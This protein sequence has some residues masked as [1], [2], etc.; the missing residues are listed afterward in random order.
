MRH[1]YT[2]QLLYLCVILLTG[3]Q[4]VSCG[5]KP[6]GTSSCT[7]DSSTYLDSCAN[8][9][10]ISPDADV[11]EAS[12]SSDEGHANPFYLLGQAFVKTKSQLLIIFELLLNVLLLLSLILYLA[13]HF[14]Q[15]KVYKHFPTSLL[16]TF[17]KSIQDPGE[18]APPKPVTLLGRVVA[19]IIGLVGVA[20]FALPAGII[21]SG[22]IAA[23][24][25]EKYAV[26]I[27]E[28]TETLQLAFERKK[29]RLTG[30]QIVPKY[31][32]VVELQ[33]RLG[34]KED[35]ILDAVRHDPHFRL[36]NLSITQN[37][38][39]H[40]QDKL[41]VE[42]YTLNTVY[43]QCIDKGSKV[44][45]FSP[46]NIVDPIMGWW[47]YYLAKIGGFNYI[48][49]ELGQTRPYQSFFNYNQ[50]EETPGHK[51]FLD[52][53]NRLASSD[54][55]WIFSLMPASGSN[56]P[57]YPTQFH[58][59][60]GSKKGDTTYSDPTIT[61]IDTAVFEAF[62]KSVSKLLSE[63]YSLNSDKQLYHDNSNPKQFA[64]HLNS[65]PNAITLRVAWSVTC[66]DMRAIKIAQEIAEQINTK[67]LGLEGNPDT[68]DLKVKDIGFEGYGD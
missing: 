62:Y 37:A 44:T 34:L 56:E 22:F 54:D 21:S 41:A 18:M 48:S 11:A 2:K 4:L 36:T 1:K 20:L 5:S 66:W 6:Q 30:Y 67:I 59:G 33:A 47:S 17:V 29:D 43:G 45:I 14:A 23:M 38:E 7:A 49:R 27:K 24:D 19:N 8:T 32:S 31:V 12:V 53:M 3:L 28:N 40:P 55:C 51:E 50:E 9:K 60:Y 16:W 58:F 35:E 25:D 15:P 61:L 46:S 42:H 65:K 64:R 39:E 26:Q 68:P 52:D 57:T 13:E 10:A 63:T